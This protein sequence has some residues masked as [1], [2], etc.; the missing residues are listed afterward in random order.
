MNASARGL[1]SIVG[2]G[3]T[4]ILILI[5]A[6]CAPSSIPPAFLAQQQDLAVRVY[7]AH[8]RRTRRE[9]ALEGDDVERVITDLQMLYPTAFSACRPDGERPCLS[10]LDALVQGL[11]RY[12]HLSLPKL[13]A[14]PGPEDVLPASG[15]NL[16]RMSFRWRL[17]PPISGRR[18]VPH[19]SGSAP[20]ATFTQARFF[21]GAE[22]SRGRVAV[23]CSNKR[24]DD[25]RLGGFYPVRVPNISDR[26][27]L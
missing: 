12:G 5:S 8:W 22:R 13:C 11:R 6:T 18:Q 26:A 24:D 2:I 27:N 1:S 14:T 10:W 25:P 3:V 7:C 4:L 19:E 15:F 21:G 17:R 9:Q 20:S 23:F 16:T